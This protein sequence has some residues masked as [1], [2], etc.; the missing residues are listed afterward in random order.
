M[1]LQWDQSPSTS[2]TIPTVIIGITK[3]LLSLAKAKEIATFYKAK[4]N[5]VTHYSLLQL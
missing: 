5:Q 3:S 1:A 4:W 2:K